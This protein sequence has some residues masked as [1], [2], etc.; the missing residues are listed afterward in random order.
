MITPFDISPPNQ[1]YTLLEFPFATFSSPFFIHRFQKFFLV[2]QTVSKLPRQKVNSFAENEEFDIL[3]GN[4]F[5]KPKNFIQS[6]K[7]GNFNENGLSKKHFFKGK[8]RM[9]LNR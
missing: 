7:C 8:N 1:S 2:K 5:N 6:R 3:K 4:S 9:N